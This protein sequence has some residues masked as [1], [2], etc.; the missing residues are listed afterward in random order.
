MKLAADA[1]EHLIQVPLI[2]RARPAPLERVGER[3]AEA[4]APGADALVAH[5]D[6]ALGQD[7][8]DLAQAQAE[9]VVEPHGVADDLGRETEAAVGAGLGLHALRSAISLLAMPS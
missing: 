8:L 1:D 7:Q 4:P 3:P 9:A 5:D 2:A 6:A